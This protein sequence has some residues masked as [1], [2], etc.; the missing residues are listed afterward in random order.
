MPAFPRPTGMTTQEYVFE[1][2]R[3][4]IMVGAFKPGMSLTIR[5]IADALESSPTPVRE[6]L[7][8]LTSVGALQLL[9]NRRIV[10]PKTTPARFEELI[11]LRIVLESHAARRAV[12]HLSELQIDELVAFDDAVETAITA[13]D[14][15]GALISNQEFH[16]RIYKANPAQVAM[17][18][19]ESLWLQLGPILGIA[20]EHVAEFYLVDR[21]QEAIEA[22]RRRDEEA[23]A[24]AIGADIR[25]GVGGLDGRAVE[26]LLAMSV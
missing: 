16:R 26:R 11:A 7:R 20:M 3:Q 6:A 10:V 21:H 1:R 18:L 4:A 8:Q 14:K 17:P 19:I 9:E 25:E 5:G 23:V 2:L 22:L 24:Q 12:V 15:A 13:G